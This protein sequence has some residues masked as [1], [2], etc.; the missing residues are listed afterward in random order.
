MYLC[1][2]SNCL[3]GC[4]SAC[5]ILTYLCLPNC[6]LGCLLD[7]NVPCFPVCLIF[8]CL[9]AC[10]ILTYLYVCLN[11]CLDACLIRPSLLALLLDCLYIAC[12]VPP[13]LPYCLLVYCACLGVCF[14]PTHLCLVVRLLALLLVCSTACS[15]CV[16]ASLL[17]YFA[18][19]SA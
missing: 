17:T 14:S 5:L 19:T 13:Y 18:W 1:V 15:K 2:F 16:L 11:V 6:L 9:F 8:A 7:T 3:L 4:L 12:N 10:L